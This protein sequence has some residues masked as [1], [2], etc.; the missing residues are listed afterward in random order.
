MSF[1]LSLFNHN[2]K[3]FYRPSGRKPI[4]AVLV[5]NISI[6]MMNSAILKEAKINNVKTVRQTPERI[7]DS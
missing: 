4:I 2:D 7:S 5:T 3:A 6:E 1:K